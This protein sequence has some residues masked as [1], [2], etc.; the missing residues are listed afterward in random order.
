MRATF[1][2][3]NPPTAM[4]PTHL[5]ATHGRRSPPP[6]HRHR[7]QAHRISPS[8]SSTPTGP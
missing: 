5:A 3:G 2:Q 1:Q 6:R 7:D 8:I 4:R